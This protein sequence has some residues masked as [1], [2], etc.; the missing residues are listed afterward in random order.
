MTEEDPL[1]LVG[2]SISEQ[3]TTIVFPSEFGIFDRFD[4]EQDLSVRLQT[5]LPN[6]TTA[7]VSITAVEGNYVGWAR[8]GNFNPSGQVRVPSLRG[9]GMG[10]F[11]ATVS[12]R[13]FVFSSDQTSLLP[14]CLSP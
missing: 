1:L 9:D 5:G 7:E 14:D 4:L 12:R 11:G 10:V 3:D 13:F 8:G 2:L 6:S